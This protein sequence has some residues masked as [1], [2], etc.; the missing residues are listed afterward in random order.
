MKTHEIA[1][2]VTLDDWYMILA[3]LFETL[4]L[5]LWIVNF[6]STAKLRGGAKMIFF[7]DPNNYVAKNKTK[8]FRLRL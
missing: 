3:L 1:N 6:Y 7:I 2:N 5:K 4:W 8:Y